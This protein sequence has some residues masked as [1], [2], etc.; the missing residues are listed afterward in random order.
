MNLI[1]VGPIFV[2]FD[3][4]TTVRDLTPEAGT[5]PRLVRI[6]FDEGHT[7]DITAQAQ[8]LLDW[9]ISQ[10]TDVTPTAP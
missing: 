6:E 2:N 1:R 5:G 3:R 8:W 10:A 9:M 4:V 7:V